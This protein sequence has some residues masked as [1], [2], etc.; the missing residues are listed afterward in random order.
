MNS[1]NPRRKNLALWP[2]LPDCLHLDHWSR[3]SLFVK[4]MLR[5]HVGLCVYVCVCVCVCVCVSGFLFSTYEKNS[6]GKD[7]S[8]QLEKMR[9]FVSGLLNR[10]SFS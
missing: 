5:M 4:T 6:Q 3:P 9:S 1:P 8:P 10:T 2:L 7:N